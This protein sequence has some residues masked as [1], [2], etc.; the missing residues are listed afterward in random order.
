MA[1]ASGRPRPT[2]SYSPGWLPTPTPRTSRPR[3]RV[4]RVA[5]CLATATARRRGS[6]TTQVPRAA[7]S[8]AVAATVRTTMH[9]RQ[10]PCQKRW[11]QAHRAPAPASSARRQRSA[12][13]ASGSARDRRRPRSR[14]RPARCA[15]RRSAGS[16]RRARGVEVVVPG[17]HRMVPPGPRD[18]R[19]DRPARRRRRPGR[20]P[21]DGR[22]AGTAEW[23][24]GR[25]RPPVPGPGGRRKDDTW[26]PTR[27]A[28]RRRPAR[29]DADAA[30]RRGARRAAG[31]PHRDHRARCAR[32]CRPT[33]ATWS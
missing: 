26:T 24:G 8:V 25:R 1:P 27:P 30:D 14:P 18:G 21:A 29:S 19:V 2:C 32:P 6:W 7:R 28:S 16:V 20:R 33:G 4:W 31:R 15:G 3:L 9:S 12:S 17:P 22:G 11:S 13:S 10:G 23:G 5:A